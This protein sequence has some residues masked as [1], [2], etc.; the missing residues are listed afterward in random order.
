MMAVQL[1]RA[2][3]LEFEVGEATP[4]YEEVYHER[5]LGPAIT[6]AAAG[7]GMLR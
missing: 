1:E 2:E 4:N 6:F 7:D 5:R 3:L